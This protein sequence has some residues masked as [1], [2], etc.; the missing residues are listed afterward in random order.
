MGTVDDIGV[1]KEDEKRYR[2]GDDRVEKA[3]PELPPRHRRTVVEIPEEHR[4]VHR[5]DRH[6]VP[7]R[8]RGEDEDH[9]KRDERHD[10]PS[11][12]RLALRLHSAHVLQYRLAVV[13]REKL[14]E[15]RQKKP[16]E[17]RRGYGAS[18]EQERVRLQEAERPPITDK[19]LRKV[20]EHGR[21]FALRD[22]LSIM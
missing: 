4:R 21:Y 14:P 7:E 17:K 8:E 15:A 2:A 12:C 10:K 13:L 19:I 18:R 3:L 20:V 1:A 5:E 16:H 6:Q 22:F 11:A 9:R